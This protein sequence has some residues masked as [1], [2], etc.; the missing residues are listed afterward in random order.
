MPKDMRELDHTLVK[1]V[2][3]EDCHFMN[4]EVFKVVDGLLPQMRMHADGREPI[5]LYDALRSM[6]W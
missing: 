4:A 6:A 2:H 1:Q 3:R 5:I